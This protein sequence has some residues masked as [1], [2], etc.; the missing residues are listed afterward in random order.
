MVVQVLLQL[1]EVVAG[2]ADPWDG[3]VRIEGEDELQGF[4]A[5]LLLG[6]DSDGPG[7]YGRGGLAWQ[8]RH[9]AAGGD[10]EE[11]ERSSVRASANPQ[12]GGALAAD[13]QSRKLLRMT[14]LDR[15]A[16][17]AAS[18]VDQTQQR[19]CVRPPTRRSEAPLRA[20]GVRV[21]TARRHQLRVVRIMVQAKR[22]AP[23]RLVQVPS[24]RLLPSRA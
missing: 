24:V 4:Q 1:V 17:C 15:W 14:V 21:R 13:G 2:P 3:M 18:Q 11:R 8:R 10:C 19:I 20:H 22:D 6:S 7:S 5:R 9:R 16:C 12:R 23:L